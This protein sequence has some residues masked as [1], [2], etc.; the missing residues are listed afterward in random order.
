MVVVAIAVWAPPFTG[1]AWPPP[2]WPPD[3]EHWVTF[4][5]L[6]DKVDPAGTT[7]VSG[8]ALS[9]QDA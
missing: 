6:Y 5:Q 7:I 3:N 9:E 4:L 1:T 8:L 2:N